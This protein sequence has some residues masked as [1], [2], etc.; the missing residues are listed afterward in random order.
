MLFLEQ[1]IGFLAPHQ[2]LGCQREGALLCE[3]C[4]SEVET[5]MPSRCYRCHAATQDSA[6]CSKCRRSSYLRHVWIAGEYTGPSKQLV[7]SLKFE[8]AKDAAKTIATLIEGT[9]PYF[10][11]SVII[12]HVP[13]ATSRVRIRG[14][15]QSQ[16]I[17]R[18]LSRRLGRRHIALLA[19]HG[20]SRQ[21]GASRAERLRQLEGAFSPRKDFLI[22]D[23]HIILVDDVLTT[24]ATL[25]QAAK[26]L[27]VAGARQV[28]AIIFAQ[29]L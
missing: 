5:P 4:L 17:A 21:V 22:K 14:Y 20:Q 12:S 25:E 1:V 3:W 6:V 27:K 26:A 2:C 7:H 9:I 11:K 10:D 18:A 8:R 13:A 23:A 15:D 24:G 28:D 29:R 16:L 19:R